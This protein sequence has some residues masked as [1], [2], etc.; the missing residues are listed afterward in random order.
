MKKI[1]LTGGFGYIG[2]YFFEKYR[3]SYDFHILDTN[4]FKHSKNIDIDQ[5][6]LFIKD[7]RDISK[8]DLNEIE[9]II[10]MGELSNDPLGD[11]NKNITNEINTLLDFTRK[12]GTYNAAI[13][14]RMI[15]EFFEYCLYSK[16]M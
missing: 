5:N 6:R 11:L 1:L 14:M 2:S 15:N 8:T 16:N 3:H 12:S 4:Y 9:I 10:H 7:I 13:K